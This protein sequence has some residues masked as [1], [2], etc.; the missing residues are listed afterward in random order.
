MRNRYF[1]CGTITDGEHIVPEVVPELPTRTRTLP[2]GRMVTRVCDWAAS[3]EFPTD[4]RC[5]VW[6]DVTEAEFA[7]LAYDSSS[8]PNGFDW[9]EV[10]DD[11]TVTLHAA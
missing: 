4:A 3:Y 8:N 9:F 5:V 10:A 7:E 2:T 11:G 1:F 6:A